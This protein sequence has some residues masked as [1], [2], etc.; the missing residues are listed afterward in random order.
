MPI[1]N[2]QQ[3]QQALQAQQ[4]Q[5]DLQ[6]QNL[7]M[8][9]RRT[10]EKFKPLNLL[11]SAAGVIGSNPNIA[12]ST[13]GSTLAIG[14]GMLSKKLLVSNSS[15]GFRR[16]MGKAVAFAVAKSIAV[17]AGTVTT[18]GIKLLKRWLK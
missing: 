7:Q 18:A 12:T 4:Q 10:M 17:N 1:T 2:Y 13:V 11:K 14:A 16:M 9:Y 6:I 3:L 15:N 8:Q 5:S